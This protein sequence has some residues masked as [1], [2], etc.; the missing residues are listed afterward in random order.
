MIQYFEDVNIALLRITGRLD[1]NT[2]LRLKVELDSLIK[3]NRTNVILDASTIDFIDSWGIGTLM[4]ET[5]TLRKIG[6][7][8]KVAC[9]DGQP[10]QLFRKSNLYKYFD[11]Y[12]NVEKAM[13]SFKSV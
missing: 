11:T 1:R 6:G 8:L 13:E 3:Q 5:A 2:G 12:P 10:K 9:L 7:A 4:G